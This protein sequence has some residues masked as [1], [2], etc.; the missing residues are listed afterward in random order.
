[1]NRTVAATRA[2]RR[3]A[4]PRAYRRPPAWHALAACATADPDAWFPEQDNRPPK[5]VLSICST[6]PV[7]DLCLDQAIED[8]EQFGIWGGLNRAQRNAITTAAGSERAA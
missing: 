5:A 4:E 1:M 6:C 2:Q 7:A 3:R 8:N